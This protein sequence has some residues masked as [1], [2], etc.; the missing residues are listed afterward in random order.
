MRENT[1]RTVGVFPLVSLMVFS[2]PLIFFCLN[3]S[4]PDN[5]NITAISESGL[6]TYFVSLGC[7]FCLL[8]SL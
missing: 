8:A 3:N 5:F 6:D 4:L 2:L 7:V 1:D